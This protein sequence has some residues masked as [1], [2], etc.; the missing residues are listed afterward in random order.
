METAH[1][2]PRLTATT[3][4]D[5]ALTNGVEVGDWVGDGGVTGAGCAVLPLHIRPTYPLRFTDPLH[6]SAPHRRS[7]MELRS[8]TGS[9]MAGSRVRDCAVEGLSCGRPHGSGSTHAARLSPGPVN[10]GSVTRYTNERGRM[11][12]CRVRYRR[13]DDLVPYTR[14]LSCGRPHRSGSTHAARLSPGPGRR[15]KRG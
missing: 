6:I 4:F 5:C 14:G 13:L 15:G 1:P 10:R 12:W 2:L 8:E 3:G 11:T 7:P 9:G